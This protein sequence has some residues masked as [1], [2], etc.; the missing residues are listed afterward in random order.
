MAKRKK[1]R[2]QYQPPARTRPAP[3]A[4]P[5][6]STGRRRTPT[7]LALAAAVAVA[8]V[9]AVLGIVLTRPNHA[10][11][12]SSARTTTSPA[13]T[14]RVT[15]QAAPRGPVP[16]RRL[17]GVYCGVCHTLADAGA[18]GADGPNLDRVRPTKAR[19]L[20]AIRRGGLGSGE[21]PAGI[22]HGRTAARVAAY[23]ARATHSR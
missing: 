20:A 11:T 21:M 13:T 16:A 7:R 15:T 9:A 22:F 3:P 17:F 2:R 14:G 8:V 5:T 4:A 10:A 19:V 6:R 18:V 12:T 1:R 23:V